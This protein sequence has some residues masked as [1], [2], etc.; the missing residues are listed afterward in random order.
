MNNTV[1]TE[2]EI[3]IWC[4]LIGTIN[5]NQFEHGSLEHTQD[6][7][8]DIHGTLVRTMGMLDIWE[9]QS[10]SCR[11][12]SVSLNPLNALK[13]AQTELYLKWTEMS[14]PQHFN[15]YLCTV[16]TEMN[17]DSSSSRQQQQAATNSS[18]VQHFEIVAGEINSD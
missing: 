9:I 4:S 1:P 10:V 13:L 5:Q 16:D 6:N 11:M 7:P 8:N 15:E 2:L 17:V 14:Q 18:N 12:D 3:M